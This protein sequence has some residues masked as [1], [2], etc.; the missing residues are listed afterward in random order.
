M[1]ASAWL[2]IGMPLPHGIKAGRVLQHGAGWQII[3]AEVGRVLVFDQ[4]AYDTWEPM[5]IAESAIEFDFL[6]DIYWIIPSGAR[7]TLSN[8]ELAAKPTSVEEGI[9]FAE[10]MKKTRNIALLDRGNGAIY[11]EEAEL[12]L[13]IVD[14]EFFCQDD[15][16]LL[17]LWISGGVHISA[18][19]IERMAKL[20]GNLSKDDVRAI[21]K[22]AGLFDDDKNRVDGRVDTKKETHG[23]RPAPG[24]EF[25]LP[26]RA[27]L[28]QFFMD[29]VLDIVENREKYELLGI[30]SPGAIILH[31]APG[32][33]KTFAAQALANYLGW[34]KFEANA[35][36]IASPYIHE[37]SRKIS[38]LFEQAIGAAPSVLIIDEM[39]AFLSDRS[40]GGGFNQHRV[41]EMAEF[42]RRIPEAVSAGVLL[43]GMTNRIETIDTAILRR[44]RFDHII[45]VPN[46]QK[47]EI[48]GLL[49]H[50]LRDL[51][52]ATDL[53]IPDFSRVLEGRPLS[54][55]TFVVREA[56]RLAAKNGQRTINKANFEAALHSTAARQGTPS[57]KKI[58]FLER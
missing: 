31:G 14:N 46:A 1:S 34:P 29:H 6:G 50:L 56:S 5:G 51:P 32:C 44:G 9:K 45:E 38:E 20:N 37:S 28:R 55:V 8:V 48:E 33:G 21:V 18:L 57:G 4:S 11:A 41:E 42:L 22:A 23:E 16:H 10:T 19:K 52:T 30:S 15:P 2:P 47:E 3:A 58:G 26:G 13:P 17:G 25:V 27:E 39:D 53:D 49:H 24:K 40:S 12:F 35:S 7:Q 43:I 54:D 36:S